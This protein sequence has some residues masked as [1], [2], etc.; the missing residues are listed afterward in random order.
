M[1]RPLSILLP[2]ALLVGCFSS[3]PKE[4][5]FYH[6]TGPVAATEQ[7]S[8][9]TIEVLAFGAAGGYDTPRMAYR[10]AANE[11][12]FYAHH[13]WAA[14]PATQVREMVASH[15][16]ASGRFALVGRGSKSRDPDAYLSGTVVAM[17]EIDEGKTWK[18]RVAVRLLLRLGKTD[19]VLM[20]HAFDVREPCA[21]RH[22]REVA[23]GISKALTAQMKTLAPKIADAVL[24]ATSAEPV[25]PAIPQ[26]TPAPAETVTED[27]S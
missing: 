15:L 22:P 13:K 14:D 7:G 26:P 6:L 21:N 4:E 25:E 19:E 12:R 3:T 17:E 8:G 27:G 5:H 24:A 23:V 2:A 20:R 11:L 10:V 9:P 16:R 18:A 1:M